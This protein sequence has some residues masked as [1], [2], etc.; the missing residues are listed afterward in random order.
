MPPPKILARNAGVVVLGLVAGMI[1]NMAFVILNTSVFFPLPPGTDMNDPVQFKAYLATLPQT[2]YV[3]VLVAHVG[4][5]FVGAWVAARLAGSHPMVLALVVG[6]L[7]LLAGIGNA[8]QVPL[9]T[10][11]YVEFPLYLVV[12]W[13]AGRMVTGRK[14][15]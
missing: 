7:S 1:V 5:S 6:V 10:W 2:A 11:M 12:A 3:L 8:M 13:L 14:A 15:A 9:P 4:M